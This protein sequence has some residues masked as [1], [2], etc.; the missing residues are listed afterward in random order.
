MAIW[1]FVCMR[2]AHTLRQTHREK[3]IVMMTSDQLMIVSSHPQRS[4]PLSASCAERERRKAIVR[5]MRKGKRNL[6]VS[7]V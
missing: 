3:G 6:P 7:Q 1:L 4:V 2:V 5:L